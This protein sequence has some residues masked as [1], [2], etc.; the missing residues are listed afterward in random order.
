VILN[1]TDLLQDGLPVLAKEPV[2]PKV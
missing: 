1:P 2:A